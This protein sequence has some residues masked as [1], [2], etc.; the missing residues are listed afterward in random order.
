MTLLPSALLYSGDWAYFSIFITFTFPKSLWT[1]HDSLRMLCL[2][3]C[4]HC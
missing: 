2:H 3:S 4:R 1:A